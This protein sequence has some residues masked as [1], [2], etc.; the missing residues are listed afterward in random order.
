MILTASPSSQQKRCIL[1]GVRYYRDNARGISSRRCRTGLSTGGTLRIYLEGYNR[2]ITFVSKHIGIFLY[3]K[4]NFE[5]SSSSGGVS[6]STCT[7]TAYIH[8]LSLAGVTL[9]HR[10]RTTYRPCRIDECCR[11]VMCADDTGSHQ[12]RVDIAFNGFRHT[13]RQ[14]QK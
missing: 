13:K 8:I 5:L 2:Q 1:R 10:W 4:N 12:L 11:C 3:K 14:Q 7:T 9:H 6:Q